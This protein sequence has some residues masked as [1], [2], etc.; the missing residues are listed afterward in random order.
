MGLRVIVSASFRGFVLQF[1]S[2]QVSIINHTGNAKNI[3]GLILD[4]VICV[5][6]LMNSTAAP[7]RTEGLISIKLFI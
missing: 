6:C 3:N 1:T 4:K 5:R 7:R 2:I